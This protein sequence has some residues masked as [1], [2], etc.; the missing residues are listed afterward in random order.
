MPN[1]YAAVKV[2]A[3]GYKFD[4]KAEYR[5]YEELRMMVLAGEITDLIVHPEYGIYVTVFAVKWRHE[6]K[7]VG[8][9]TADFSYYRA[10]ELVVEDVK[11]GRATR[12]EAYR[13]RK[14]CVE[15]SYGIKITEV[16]M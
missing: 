5:R 14:R 13:L 11:G 10:D 7:C 16:E 3:D 4:S 8:K 15:A 9:Y 1:K 2:E 12:T 6:A